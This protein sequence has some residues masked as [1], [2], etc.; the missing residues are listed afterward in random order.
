MADEFHIDDFLEKLKVKLNF[1]GFRF[2][3]ERVENR[4]TMKEL[5]LSRLSLKEKLSDLKIEN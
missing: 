2:S 3:R 1:Y 4:E 5:S